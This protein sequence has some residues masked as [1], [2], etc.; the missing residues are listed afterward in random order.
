MEK[1]NKRK[2]VFLTGFF[3]FF[4]DHVPVDDIPESI[5]IFCPPVLVFEVVGMFPDINA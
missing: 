3:K 1:G 5:D 2:V 4:R